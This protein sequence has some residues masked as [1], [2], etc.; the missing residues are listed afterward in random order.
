MAEDIRAMV[1]TLPYDLR[2]LIDRA[3]LMLGYAGGLRRSEIV[4]LDIHKDDTPDSGGWLEVSDEGM[5]L[6]LN[7]KTGC[8]PAQGGS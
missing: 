4:S 7:A 3:I 2:G 5:L 1:A 8:E 6:P